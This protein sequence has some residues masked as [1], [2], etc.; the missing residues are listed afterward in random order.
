MQGR[1]DSNPQ[2]PVLETGALPIE[3]LPFVPTSDPGVG[4]G[5]RYEP[6]ATSGVRASRRGGLGSPGLLVVHVGPAPTA[7]LL[8]L[9]PLAGVYL[10]LGSDVV[11]ALALLTL[12]GDLRSLVGRHIGLTL[13]SLSHPA[14]RSPQNPPERSFQ[15]AP[16]GPVVRSDGQ[17]RTVDL[18]IMSRAL[19]PTE[20]RRQRAP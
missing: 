14:G 11:P 1:R 17:I 19:S 12:K 8:D 20:L 18:S 5:G 6:E 9:D 4:V 10:G 3:P 7:V 2:P 16:A 13:A 15:R